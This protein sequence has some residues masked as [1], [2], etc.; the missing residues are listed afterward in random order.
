M[1][2]NTKFKADPYNFSNH[3]LQENDILKIMKLLQ[4]D[5]FKIKD[6]NNYRKAFIHKSYTKLK[7]YEEYS[8]PK[9][10]LE[11][12]DISYATLEFLGD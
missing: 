4:I 6:I 11:L 12:Q 7:D 3:L 1:E 9:D 8:K 2:P 5:N 10:C